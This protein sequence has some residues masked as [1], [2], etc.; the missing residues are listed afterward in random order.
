MPDLLSRG[1]VDEAA[2]IV[3]VRWGICERVQFPDGCVEKLLEGEICA[4]CK[5]GFVALQTVI[6]E[7]LGR[8]NRASASHP[9]LCA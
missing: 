6:S 4:S 2:M 5:V 1:K 7:G 3:N 8:K 9:G